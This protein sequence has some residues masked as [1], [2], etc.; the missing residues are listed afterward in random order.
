[1]IKFKYI[2]YVVFFPTAV[3]LSSGAE[4][5]DKYRW[6]CDKASENALTPSSSYKELFFITDTGGG[7]R[8]GNNVRAKLEDIFFWNQKLGW[9]CGAKGVFKSKDGGLSW[10]RMLP[11]QNYWKRVVMTA[12]DKIWLLGI[13]DG[14]QQLWRSNDGGL[15]WR[16][17]Y[18]EKN[19]KNSKGHRAHQGICAAGDRVILIA[20]SSRLLVFNN[21]D[22][23]SRE[24]KIPSKMIKVIRNVSVPGDTREHVQLSKENINEGQVEIDS[25]VYILGENNNGKCVLLKTLDGFNT[26]DIVPIDAQIKSS[27]YIKMF[28]LSSMTGW[29]GSADGTLWATSDGGLSWENISIPGVSRHQRCQAL[30][31]DKL[32]RGFVSVSNSNALRQ[33]ETLYMTLDGGYSWKSTLGGRKDIRTIYGIGS[34]AVWMAGNVPGHWPNDLIVILKKW[35]EN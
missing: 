20:A 29:I 12:P 17:V 6:H 30:Y 13:V 27:W 11:I 4:L 15:S 16:V 25:A 34:N 28:F 24:I 21:D 8:F 5:S 14:F 33:K 2:F 3:L 19:E 26:F 7:K 10:Q 22:D 31:F 18:N 32:G 35:P 23:K 1:M 9:A